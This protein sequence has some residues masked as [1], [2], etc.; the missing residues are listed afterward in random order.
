MLSHTMIVAYFCVFLWI[1]FLY[2]FIFNPRGC[3]ASEIL[4]LFVCGLF[5]LTSFFHLIAFKYAYR[6]RNLIGQDS[7]IGRNW[8]KSIDYIY[9]LLS[10][11]SIL[12]IVISTTTTSEGSTSFSA[13]AAILLGL[14]VALRITR[15]SIEIF[16]WDKRPVNPDDTFQI[17]PFVFWSC[18][19]ILVKTW[20]S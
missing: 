17:T 6:I 19:M 2:M 11:F 16:E 13:F 4:Q 8:V 15:T 14:A 1:T 5:L 12:R 7:L 3:K 20:I 9:L 10:S 18:Q